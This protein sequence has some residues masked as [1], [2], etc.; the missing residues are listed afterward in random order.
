MSATT[1]QVGTY[2]NGQD[3]DTQDAAVAFY[4][5]LESYYHKSPK[6]Q[7]TGFVRKLTCCLALDYYYGPENSSLW[8]CNKYKLSLH[9]L[10]WLMDRNQTQLTSL[11]LLPLYIEAKGV[12]N[13]HCMPRRHIKLLVGTR[14][15]AEFFANKDNVTKLAKIPEIAQMVAHFKENLQ[16]LEGISISTLTDVIKGA[17]HHTRSG[18]IVPVYGIG[19]DCY[20]N[21]VFFARVALYFA[22]GIFSAR[23]FEVL[24][25]QTEL[26]EELF[27]KY[28]KL[29]DTKGNIK[30]TFN[31][32]EFHGK[33]DH[34]CPPDYEQQ[35]WR[36]MPN[37]GKPMPS[38]DDTRL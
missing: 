26:Y 4:R 15:L 17:K 34:I 18:I 25:F 11:G 1:N 28:E 36:H 5:V 20:G 6:S 37:S 31:D 27:L 13:I 7:D 8:T 35:F 24:P 23:T 14:I 3:R 38:V 10:G 22:R 16:C 19:T 2:H 12:A 9:V 32:P 21:S 30:T 33:N 29:S